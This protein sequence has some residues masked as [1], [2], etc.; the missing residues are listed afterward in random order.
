VGRV[1]GLSV[2]LVAKVLSEILRL[3]FLRRNEGDH[4]CSFVSSRRTSGR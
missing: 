2:G 3:S 4:E 1:R